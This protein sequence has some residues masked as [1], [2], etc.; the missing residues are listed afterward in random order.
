MSSESAD[1]NKVTGKQTAIGCL[2]I[3]VLAIIIGIVCGVTGSNEPTVIRCPTVPKNLGDGF[4][5]DLAV[6]WAAEDAIRDILQDPDSFEE[7]GISSRAMWG[8]PRADGSEYYSKLEVDFTA[9]NALGGTVRGYATVDL[10]E[11]SSGCI[12]SNAVLW[13]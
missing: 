12:V 5:L 11:T 13:E 6:E 9:R 3:I 4:D 8:V 7:R 2:G 10:R 1:K